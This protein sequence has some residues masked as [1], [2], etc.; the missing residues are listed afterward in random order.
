MFNICAHKYRVNFV[1]RTHLI[2]L[3]QYREFSAND[4]SMTGLS[5]I[6]FAFGLPGMIGA[7][8]L[9]TITILEK[10]ELSCKSSSNFS[11]CKFAYEHNFRCIS[12]NSNFLS[13]HVNY[14]SCNINISIHKLYLA[15]K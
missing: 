3:L 11:N 15:F 14:C 5:L 10:Y 9:V 2:T 13:T 8:I 12:L 4:V 7:K 1:S 6:A